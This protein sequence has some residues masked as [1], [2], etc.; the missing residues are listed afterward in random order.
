MEEASIE[1]QHKSSPSKNTKTSFVSIH[2]NVD[3]NCLKIYDEN[4]EHFS[5]AIILEKEDGQVDERVIGYDCFYR[6]GLH[7]MKFRFH[8]QH[9]LWNIIPRESNESEK[10]FDWIFNDVQFLTLDE[11][12]QIILKRCDQYFQGERK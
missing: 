8:I 10:R 6:Y 2:P 4:N 12:I 3:Y 7:R 1:Q 5:M 9:G 11:Q